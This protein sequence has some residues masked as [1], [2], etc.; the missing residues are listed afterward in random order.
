M[1]RKL[2]IP[3]VAASLLAGCVSDYSLRGGGGGGSYYYGRPS[4][5]YNYYG[6]YGGYYGPGY[7]YPYGEAYRYRGYG[8]P[9]YYGGGYYGGYPY[10]YYPRPY[11]P[12]R[13]GRP[14]NPSRPPNPPRQDG[15]VPWRDTH[16]VG[17]GAWAPNNPVQQ[18]PQ[19]RAYST[20]QPRSFSQPQMQPRMPTAP[21]V[22]RDGGRA[23]KDVER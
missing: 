10:G 17:G 21:S 22:R 13:P 19:P 5:D 2:M 1:I 18:Q 16:R 3:L 6:G 8:Y 11:Y 7:G 12:N 9:G 4:V 14:H 15:G 20:P 23:W